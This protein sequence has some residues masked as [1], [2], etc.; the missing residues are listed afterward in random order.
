MALIFIFV[1]WRC[2]PKQRGHSGQILSQTFW[3]ESSLPP[4]FSL[5]SRIC[6]ASLASLS[7]RRK[8]G[9]NQLRRKKIDQSHSNKSYYVEDL[10]WKK[11]R[12]WKNLKCFQ[13]LLSIFGHHWG[14][15]WPPFWGRFQ[16]HFFTQVM[17]VIKSSNKVMMIMISH[18]SWMRN[19]TVFLQQQQH[20]NS[21]SNICEWL[22]AKRTTQSTPL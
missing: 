20:H 13:V 2:W 3:Q 11:K 21:N 1:L 16:P 18:R 10:L 4:L 5:L 17:F 7:N 19:T 8:R 15:I 6:V 9:C 14:L 12:F 22:K